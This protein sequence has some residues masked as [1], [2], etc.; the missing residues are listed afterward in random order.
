MILADT[1]VWADFISHGDDRMRALLESGDVRMHPMVRGELALGN[2]A[3]RAANLAALDSLPT[4][5]VATHDEVHALIE[6]VP[7]FGTD[8]GFVDAHLLA[9]VL[10]MPGGRLWTRDRRLA[11]VAAKLAILYPDPE[12]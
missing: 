9:S 8:V 4:A 2:L 5:P 6:N 12:A 11:A 3:R 7:L 10:L 1:M